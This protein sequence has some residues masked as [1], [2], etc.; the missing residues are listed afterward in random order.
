MRHGDRCATWVVTLQDMQE[1]VLRGRYLLQLDEAVNISAPTLTRYSAPAA[2]ATHKL[3]LTDGAAV[4]RW[5]ADAAVSGEWRRCVMERAGKVG[6]QSCVRLECA[7]QTQ[8]GYANIACVV[9]VCP[10]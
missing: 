2:G 1:M 5:G 10:S 6:L 4:H 3:L 8:A 7:A 9:P